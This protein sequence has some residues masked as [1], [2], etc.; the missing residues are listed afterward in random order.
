MN[1]LR[2]QLT[3]AVALFSANKNR[4]PAIIIMS[5]DFERNFI[6]EIQSH[7]EKLLAIASFDKFLDIKVI[8][9]VDVKDFEI[10]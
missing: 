6:F 7:S 8:R 1:N 3:D 9:S 10:Y 4:T 2:K 5:Y